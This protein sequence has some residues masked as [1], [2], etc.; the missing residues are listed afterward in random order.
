MGLALCTLPV[1]VLASSEEWTCGAEWGTGECQ[2]DVGPTRND[3]FCD[4]CEKRIDDGEKPKNILGR[5]P[6]QRQIMTSAAPRKSFYTAAINQLAAARK[7][8]FGF[9]RR[10]LFSP[11]FVKLCEEI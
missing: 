10:R 1:S 3:Q 8:V 9:R 7:S 2:T 5:R 4:D 6:A 11:Q